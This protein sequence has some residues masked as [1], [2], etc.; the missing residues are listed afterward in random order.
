MIVHAVVVVKP[1]AVMA[2]G[3]DFPKQILS[4]IVHRCH[5]AW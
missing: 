3:A 1:V 5:L 2:A 4:V